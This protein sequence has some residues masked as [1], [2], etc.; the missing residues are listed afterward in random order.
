MCPSFRKW[1]ITVIDEAE[2]E[3]RQTELPEGVSVC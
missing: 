2:Q 3:E 1:V